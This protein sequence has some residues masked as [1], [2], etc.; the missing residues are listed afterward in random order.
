[1]ALQGGIST[2][3]V[4]LSGVYISTLHLVGHRHTFSLFCFCSLLWCGALGFFLHDHVPQVLIQ[5]LDLSLFPHLLCSSQLQQ[6]G[7]D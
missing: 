1:M 6:M 7:P 2:T 5:E 3:D 4:V